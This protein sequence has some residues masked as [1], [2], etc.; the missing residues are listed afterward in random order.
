LKI[1]E[2]SLYS[3]GVSFRKL[4]LLDEYPVSGKV[5]DVGCGNGLYGLYLA[6][7]GCDVLQI[8]VVDR[9]DT[10]ARCLPFVVMDAQSLT[11]PDQTFG[12]VVAFDI[13][14][15]LDN[16]VGFLQE[17]R[18][19]CFGN[20]FLSVPNADGEQIE[21]LALT[22]IHYKDKTHRREYTK[23]SLISLLINN[24]FNILKISPN[25]NTGLYRFAHALAKKNF[26]AK[27]AAQVISLQ[28]KV[29][30][31]CGL[32]ENRTVGDWYCVAEIRLDE[33]L[34][35]KGSQSSGVVLKKLKNGTPMETT[36]SESKC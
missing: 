24:G 28:C 34:R 22:H 5:L 31:K 9:R 2:L 6:A 19:V 11:F 20:L 1:P 18:R 25:F 10:R 12:S 27:V 3:N 16:D 4:K 35:K 8:D 36:N 7:K 21:E 23:E 33:Y 30:Q 32:F 13:M 17:I 29:L 26:L 15:H 14:E